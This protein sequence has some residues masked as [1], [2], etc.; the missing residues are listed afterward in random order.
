MI[1]GGGSKVWTFF[2]VKSKMIGI[3]F[4]P[5][6]DKLQPKVNDVIILIFNDLEYHVGVDQINIRLEGEPSKRLYNLYL[7]FNTN[8][9]PDTFNIE[10]ERFP[11]FQKWIELCLIHI[12]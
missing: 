8:F 5:I 3:F 4:N 6:I 1:S 9:S 12:F 7:L 2:K 10:L 11:G